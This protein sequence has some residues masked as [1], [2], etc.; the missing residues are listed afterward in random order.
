ME[1]KESRSASEEHVPGSVAVLRLFG[2]P[3][4]F[5]FT[6]VLLVAF[7]AIGGI[8][9]RQPGLANVIYVGLLFG[10]VLVHEL[11]HALVARQYGIRTLDIVMFPMGGLARL[12]RSPKPREEFWIAIAGPAVNVV[13][14][15]V[16]LS[17]L[18][19]RQV[20]T[21][22]S[23]LTRPEALGLLEQVAFGN[24]FLAAFNMVPAFP[25]D[26]GR[27]LRA[28]LARFR[29]EHEATRIA[30]A[31]GRFLAIAMGLYGLISMHF[32][33]VFIAFFVYLGAA[34][35]S[36]S[37]RGRMLTSGVPVR[38]A[39]VTDY[40]T[41]SHGETIRDAA[42][43][44]LATSQQ[45]FPVMHGDQVIGLLGRGALLRVLANQGP[46]AYVSAAMDRNYVR[47]SPEADLSEALPLM[48]HG[49]SCAL[50]M[51]GSRLIGLL[52]TDNLSEFLVLRSIGLAP[53]GS[54]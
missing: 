29:P 12:E 32:L 4:R 9:T 46:D 50:V 8:A 6:F 17:L 20:Q 34:Q 1:S 31:A 53:Q 39:M 48:S 30:T 11:G 16:L 43:L 22:L 37:V 13:I 41:L 18:E 35:E 52:T 44:L 47:L 40:R 23:T 51:E 28:V 42:N 54:A 33:L 36:A 38:S 5:H 10:S 2:V 45:D 27:V 7:L 25:M 3:I 24:L 15:A 21:A 49:G 19:W 26:G 14:A